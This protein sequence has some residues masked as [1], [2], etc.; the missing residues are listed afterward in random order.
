MPVEHRGLSKRSLVMR[1][2][3]GN[4]LLGW[5]RAERELERRQRLQRTG[6]TPNRNDNIRARE[7]SRP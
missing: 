2:K 4:T 1:M 7:K 6:T 5:Q 3:S